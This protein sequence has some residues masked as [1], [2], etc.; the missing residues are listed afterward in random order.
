M[1]KIIEII[2]DDMPDWAAEA[3]EKGQLWTT[4]FER[5]KKLE[6]NI[7]GVR[8]EAI[9]WTHADNCADLDNNKD[10]RLKNVP[11]MLVRAKIDLS[12]K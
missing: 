11:D 3:M 2:P 5:I 7:E 8:A 9:G 10:P 6:H 12:G 1:E 4:V